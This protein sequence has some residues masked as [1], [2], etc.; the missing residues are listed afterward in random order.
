[1]DVF[2]LVDAAGK[3]YHAHCV[4]CSGTTFHV[5]AILGYASGVPKSAAIWEA[6]TLVWTSWAGMPNIISVDRGKEFMREVATQ[7]ARHGVTIDVAATEAAW[8]LGL[9]ERHGGIW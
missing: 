3:R 6:F 5:V 8:Q 2:S 9:I 7:A 4:I 1:M